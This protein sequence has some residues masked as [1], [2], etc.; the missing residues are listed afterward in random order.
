M[1]YKLILFEVVLLVVAVGVYFIGGSSTGTTD[2]ITSDSADQLAFPDLPVGEIQEIE[3]NRGDKTLR[4]QRKEDQN[5]EK[6]K[7]KTEEKETEGHFSPE[8]RGNWKIASYH[9]YEVRRNLVSDRILTHLRELRRGEVRSESRD[10]LER[11]G[12][13]ESSGT[14]IT[15]RDKNGKT[16][17]EIRLGNEETEFSSRQNKKSSRELVDGDGESEEEEDQEDQEP[18][19]FRYYFRPSE[20]TGNF[21]V[22]LGK[23]D[24]PEVSLNPQDWLSREIVNFEDQ[25]VNCM[26]VHDQRNARLYVVYRRE[27]TEESGN[28]QDE[29][30]GDDGDENTFTDWTLKVADFQQAIQ[31]GRGY[32]ALD[33]DRF[34]REEDVDQTAVSSLFNTMKEFKAEEVMPPFKIPQEQRKI[35]KNKLKTRGLDRPTVIVYLG[36]W[37]PQKKFVG[38]MDRLFF[39]TVPEEQAQDGGKDG[40]QEQSETVFASRLLK[41]SQQANLEDI[42]G[43]GETMYRIPV[44]KISDSDYENISDPADL[45]K[46]EKEKKEEENRGPAGLPRAGNEGDGKEE[47]QS[48]EEESETSSDKNKEKKTKNGEEQ[49]ENDPDTTEEQKRSGSDDG[50]NGGSTDGKQEESGSGSGGDSDGEE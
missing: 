3:V 20:E 25:D 33:K 17:H 12:L 2:D 13:D 36:M 27:K 6:K 30:N 19:K 32:R 31:L 9:N 48:G 50:E 40:D 45:I 49:Q 37:N 47:D 26:A 18:D 15:L 11:F 41:Q 5:Q 10:H 43:E 7:K 44:Y 35:P 29:E 4:L 38:F 34:G 1:R 28:G 16:I 8:V 24:F 23:V 14:H 39:G 46:T 22:R 21:E 42:F